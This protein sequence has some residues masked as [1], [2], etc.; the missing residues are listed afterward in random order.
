MMRGYI[1]NFKYT[2]IIINDS[3]IVL[4]YKSSCPPNHK[5]TWTTQCPSTCSALFLCFIFSL[6]SFLH[7]I[8]F[9]SSLC[10]HL[11]LFLFLSSSSYLCFSFYSSAAPPPSHSPTDLFFFFHH[12]HISAFLFILLLH[13]HLHILLLT[14]IF[15]RHRKRRVRFAYGESD[16][17]PASCPVS[18]RVDTGTPREVPSQSNTDQILRVKNSL[19]LKGPNK[20]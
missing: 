15:F 5:W 7:L 14:F 19:R 13:R 11:L 20:L 3:T 17:Y 4:L 18:G 1:N 6:S 16:P 9:I 12:H 10:F 8:V 2:N